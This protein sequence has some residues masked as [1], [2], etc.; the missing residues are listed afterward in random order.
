MT[1]YKLTTLTH[2][3]TQSNTHIPVS[4]SLKSNRQSHLVGNMNCEFLVVVG[5]GDC[6]GVPSQFS[7]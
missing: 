4:L 3:H 5:Q 1:V 6:T 2:T 7:K